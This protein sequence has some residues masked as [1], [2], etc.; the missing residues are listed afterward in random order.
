M[1]V[2]HM[3]PTMQGEGSRAGQ[4]AMFVRF[5]GCNLWGGTEA[6]RDRGNGVCA[7]WCDT[8]FHGGTS[9]TAEELA[10]RVLQET[11]GW[12]GI[13]LVVL[14]GGEP[15]LQLQRPEGIHFLALLQPHC[16]L[17]LETNGTIRIPGAVRALLDHV[18]VSPKREMAEHHL[19]HIQQR[20]GTD[21]KVVAPQW[22]PEQL[23]EMDRWDFDHFYIQP[24]DDGKTAPSIT[25]ARALDVAR[26]LGWRVSVQTHKLVGM[27]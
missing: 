20:S 2:K 4:P 6:T 12:G 7:L 5:S 21:L 9:Y 18:T 17:A 23:R 24:L 3:F 15:M 25:A 1:R 8:D 22:K 10:E 14:T 27:E 13:P 11:A 26:E 19:V 16:D